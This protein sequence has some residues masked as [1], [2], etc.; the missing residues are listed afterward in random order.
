MGLFDIFK[1]KKKLE[2]KIDYITIGQFGRFPKNKIETKNIVS[3]L[4]FKNINNIE[5]SKGTE[6]VVNYWIN[7]IKKNSQYIVNYF[8][9]MPLRHHAFEEWWDD[10]CFSEEEKSLD[11]DK[12]EKIR[13]ERK[14]QLMSEIDLYLDK[15]NTKDIR[16]LYQKY[17]PYFDYDQFVSSIELEYINLTNEYLDIQLSDKKMEFFC[18]AYESFD[19]DLN[20]TDWHNF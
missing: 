3:D 14:Y 6:D 19:K 18:A 13:E 1:K 17:L 8:M 2:D 7:L 10:W 4:K 20:G 16:E 11:N 15:Q 5:F 9:S 12:L